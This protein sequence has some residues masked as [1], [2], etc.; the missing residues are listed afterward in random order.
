MNQDCVFALNNQ[1]LE[2]PID[3]KKTWIVFNIGSQRFFRCKSIEIEKTEPQY[4]RIRGRQGLNSHRINGIFIQREE[5]VNGK[6]SFQTKT[7][8]GEEIIMWYWKRKSCWMVSWKGHVGT[9]NAYAVCKYKSIN[10]IEIPAKTKWHI[11]NSKKQCFMQDDEIIIEETSS[12]ASFA[13]IRTPESSPILTAVKGPTG[14]AEKDKGHR[15]RM[16]IAVAEQEHF[17]AGESSPAVGK[18]QDSNGENNG[19]DSASEE[20]NDVKQSVSAE[21]KKA[22]PVI[23]PKKGEDWQFVEIGEEPGNISPMSASG[24]PKASPNPLQSPKSNTVKLKEEP[25]NISPMSASE[26]PNAS[27]NPI[28]SPK[29]KYVATSYNMPTP[30]RK[31][32]SLKEKNQSG[33]RKQISNVGV[34]DAPVMSNLRRQSVEIS[35]SLGLNPLLD[36]ETWNTEYLAVGSSANPKNKSKQYTPISSTYVDDGDWD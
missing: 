1:Q 19:C 17:V 9:Q 12:H 30:T 11:W 15:A 8:D 34:S 10:P 3:I 29:S 22:P 20:D 31:N 26:T 16:S 33:S 2:S 23:E 18:P 24:T 7:V 32:K 14:N 25:G 36:E 4:I 35:S 6:P 28:Q 5:M 27:P 13:A 21:K